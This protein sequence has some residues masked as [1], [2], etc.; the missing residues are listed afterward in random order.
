[1]ILVTLKINNEYVGNKK[2]HVDILYYL[3]EYQ[4]L[5]TFVDFN[6]LLD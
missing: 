4:E 1:M 5:L 6:H 2:H 3:V